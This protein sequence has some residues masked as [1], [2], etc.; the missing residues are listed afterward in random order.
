MKAILLDAI[1]FILCLII[2]CIFIPFFYLPYLILICIR[3]SY[4]EDHATLRMHRRIEDHLRKSRD[5]HEYHQ[6]HSW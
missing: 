6:I 3:D 4:A 1:A 5:D 2:L